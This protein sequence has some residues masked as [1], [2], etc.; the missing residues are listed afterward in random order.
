MTKKQL[1]L[2]IGER[3]PSYRVDGKGREFFSFEVEL[4]HEDSSQGWVNLV[5]LS[6][7]FIG[8]PPSDYHIIRSK[9]VL[10]SLEYMFYDVSKQLG[11]SNLTKV[12]YA[13]VET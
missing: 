13:L 3:L 9:Q 11:V 2:C 10:K 1:V 4:S 5:S 7:A 12:Y 6:A 8:F